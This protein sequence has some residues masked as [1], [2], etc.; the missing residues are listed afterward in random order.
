MIS[1]HRENLETLR[2]QQDRLGRS[3]NLFLGLVVGLCLGF[4]LTFRAWL[5]AITEFRIWLLYSQVAM[6]AIVCAVL[7][8]RSG[9]RFWHRGMWWQ[10]A[11]IAFA[12]RLLAGLYVRTF[13]PELDEAHFWNFT[14]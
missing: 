14:K 6:T 13:W 1:R 9:D 8:Y 12:F 3:I 7:A 11:L 10:A 2:T 5:Y 4:I